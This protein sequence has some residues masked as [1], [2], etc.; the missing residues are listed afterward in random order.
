MI[1]SFYSAFISYKWFNAE[2][3]SFTKNSKHAYLQSWTFQFKMRCFLSCI[4]GAFHIPI[5]IEGMNSSSAVINNKLIAYYDFNNSQWLDWCFTLPSFIKLYVIYFYMKQLSLFNNSSGKL[6]GS[7]LGLNMNEIFYVKTYIYDNPVFSTFSSISL[8]SLSSAYM[9]YIVER[10]NPV[11]CS[12]NSGK[13]SSYG[14]CLWM[15][16]ITIFTVGY[17]D[18]SA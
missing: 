1:V 3:E 5:Y 12:V 7:F 17:G 2:Y 10:Q 16:L 8:L 4:V 18:M 6:L 9:I 14:N 15:V 13:F 11:D